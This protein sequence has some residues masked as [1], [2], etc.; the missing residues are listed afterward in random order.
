VVT[1]LLSRLKEEVIVVEA[2][3]DVEFVSHVAALDIGK[4]ELTACVRV[5]GDGPGAR[6]RQEIRTFGTTTPAL[7][8]LSD[9]LRSEQV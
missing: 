4:A 1:A 2:V 7:L 9:W 3:E 8:E 6:R 5:P